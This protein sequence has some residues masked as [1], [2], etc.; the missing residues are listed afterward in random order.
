MIPEPCAT[1]AP[2]KHRKRSA[3]IVLRHRPSNLADVP[4]RDPPQEPSQKIGFGDDTLLLS[5]HQD[6]I[7]VDD[8]DDIIFRMFRLHLHEPDNV[9]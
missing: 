2:P 3:Q 5:S 7:V 9:T 6:Q 1:L 8:V 4:C